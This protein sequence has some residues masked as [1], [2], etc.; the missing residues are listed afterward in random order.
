MAREKNGCSLIG[1]EFYLSLFL[2]SKKTGVTKKK[3][4]RKRI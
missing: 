4:L 2:I 1:W 3:K